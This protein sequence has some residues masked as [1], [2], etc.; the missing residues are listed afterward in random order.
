MIRTALL[1]LAGLSLM[2]CS[3]YRDQLDRADTHYRAAHYES[4]LTNLEDLDD[5]LAR[6]DAD[7]RT[8]YEYVRGMTHARL[9]Q[10]SDAR[11][12]LAIAREDSE[13]APNALSTEMRDLMT[14]TLTDL[15]TPRAEAQHEAAAAE[16]SR[17]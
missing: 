13:R 6:F 8:R 11:H 3:N 7:E 12:W 10:R 4:A 5:D 15:D 2:S 16:T 1:A 9:S 14:R 17:R